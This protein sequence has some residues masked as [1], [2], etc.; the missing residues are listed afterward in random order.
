MNVAII[1]AR[2][3]SKRIPNK[4]I[5]DFCGKPMIAWTI[6]A[7]VESMLFD[8]IVVST[9]DEAI[10]EISTYYGAEVPF[11]RT[12]FYDD[13]TPVSLVTTNVL[14]ELTSCC[15]CEYN[16]VVQLMA[17]CPLRKSTH[18]QESFEHFK[19]NNYHFQ[20][21][22]C[23]FGWQN[24]WWSFQISPEYDPIP[25]FPDALKQRSQD[26]APLY[27]PSGAIWIAETS[28]LLRVGT[29]YGNGY[30]LYPIDWH[31]AVDIDDYHDLEFAKSIYFSKQRC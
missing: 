1:P 9:E 8:K 12:Q 27:C 18:I 15:S 23:K 19:S 31:A 6:E 16:V 14:Q 10:A 11:L 26:L 21:S 20:L 17:N 7:A 24:P 4:N 2:G 3:G 28:A 29:F 13:A 30:K 22:C 5:I 25:L